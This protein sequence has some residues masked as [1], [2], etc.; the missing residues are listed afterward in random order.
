[1][2][3]NN[4]QDAAEGHQE[5]FDTCSWNVEPSAA[6]LQYALKVVLG[7]PQTSSEAD[8]ELIKQAA[9]SEVL[10]SQMIYILRV[11]GIARAKRTS[12]GDLPYMSPNLRHMSSS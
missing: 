5:E 11:P 10:A 12:P 8:A 9:R 3:D 7:H 2:S 6:V 1:M 4:N